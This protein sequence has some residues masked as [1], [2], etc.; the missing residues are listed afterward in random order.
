MKQFFSSLTGDTV[1]A[2]VLV[3]LAVGVVGMSYGSLAMAYGFPLWVPFVLSLTVLAG[4]SE[5][6]FIGIVAS[7]GNP[8]AAAAAGLLVNARHV[9]FGVSV[10]DLVGRRGAALLG[11]HIMNDE[12][13]VFGL[14]QKTPEQRRAAYWLCG[15][16]VAIIW[17]VGALLGA[18]IGK[19]LPAPETIGL[20]AVFPAILLALTLPAFKNRATLARALSGAAI[21]LAA[22]PFVATGLPVLLSLFGLLAR[23]K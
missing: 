23:K 7:G 15:L 20:D 22:V 14:S 6:M 4:A 5:F 17:P 8:L 19:L 3:V 9:P 12:S 16:G 1:K 11:C 13:V 2:I 18:G 10:R 21:S